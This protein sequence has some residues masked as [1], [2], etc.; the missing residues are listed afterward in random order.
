[1]SDTVGAVSNELSGGCGALAVDALSPAALGR[2]G[3]VLGVAEAE[4]VGPLLE[5]LVVY[6]EKILLS[7]F[8]FFFFYL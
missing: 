4:N 7:A 5:L 8:F 1:M 2:V 3:R 6:K